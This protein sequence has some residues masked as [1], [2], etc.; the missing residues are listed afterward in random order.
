[1]KLRF[2]FMYAL[3]CLG[4]GQGGKNKAPSNAQKSLIGAIFGIA[5]S[6]IPLLIVL[7]VS[8]GMISGITSRLIELDSGQ[9]KIIEM[10][11][12]SD[13]NDGRH[14]KALKERLKAQYADK[15]FFKNAWVE[16]RG[17]GLLIGNNGR[18]GGSIRA[19]EKNFFAE[20][21]KAKN[22]L[23]VVAGSAVLE[24][25]NEVLLGKKIAENLQLK[26]GD[27][28]RLL[29][30]KKSGG[31]KAVPKFSSLKVKGIISCGYQELDALWVF[32]GLDK[33]LQILSGS[34]SLTSL[35][36]ST[37]NP[38][39]NQRF[40]SFLSDLDAGL[41]DDFVANSWKNLNRAQYASFAT[42]KNL[43]MFI[44]F[45]ILLVASINISSALIMLVLERT[46]EIAIL[47]STGA[48]TRLITLSFF[49]SGMLTSVF[50]LLLGLPVGIL[51][52]LNINAL[53][54][55]IEKGIN[56]LFVFLYRLLNLNSEMLAFHILDPSYYLENIPV[57][58]DLTTLFSIVLV[59]IILSACVSIIPSTRAGRERPIDIM[60]KL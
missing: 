9:I 41:T 59:T 20:N 37:D 58:L 18:S 60:R 13:E 48:N 25:D 38:F 56:L 19:I 44:M 8:D 42:T 2:A 11:I 43:L 34:S 4:F 53:L 47:K 15:P 23:K 22:L 31:N 33:G 29:T 45:L 36:V 40:E 30:L 12:R 21:E 5:V 32:I 57:H 27:T 35:I 54:A 26:V 1:M 7:V 3:R 28:C 49:I 16:R 39:D 52:S 10:R 17:T 51:L 14:E 46:Q 6:V 55:M 50:G 24:N